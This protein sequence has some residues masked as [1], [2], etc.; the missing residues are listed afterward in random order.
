[1]NQNYLQ[2]F[3][4]KKNSNFDLLTMLI[5]NLCGLKDYVT[6]KSDLLILKSRK[7]NFRMN[8]LC[9]KVTLPSDWIQEK[10]IIFLFYRTY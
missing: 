5:N 7:L 1:M 8:V 9:V 2:F 4:P 3:F 10:S 6:S